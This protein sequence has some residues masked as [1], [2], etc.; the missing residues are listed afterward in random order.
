MNDIDGAIDHDSPTSPESAFMGAPI[1]EIP[2]KVQVA[3]P[4][5]YLDPSDPPIL[6]IHGRNDR[7][8]P[9]NQSELLVDRLKKVGITHKF[10]EVKN[11]GHGFNARPHPTAKIKPSRKSIEKMWLSWF[12]K[13][14]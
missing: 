8:V 9:L 12:R 5:R 11:A 3:N 10:I 14:L 6:I 2:E 7:M 1:Q 13:Y 4:I